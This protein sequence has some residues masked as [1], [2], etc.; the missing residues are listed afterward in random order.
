MSSGHLG[1]IEAALS[2]QKPNGGTPIVGATMLAYK[3]LYQSLGVEGDAHVVLIT[4]GSDSC[5]DFYAAQPSIPA[6]NQVEKLI[7]SGAPS[8]LGVGI[9][10]WVIGAPGSES[11]RSTLSN[12][13]IAGGTRRSPA[14]TPGSATD[15]AVG[16]CHYDMTT[17]DFESTLSEALGHI[18]S[19]VTCGAIR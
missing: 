19:V 1:A 8:A 17:G 18:L 16:D 7:G 12:L 5:A 11:G 15:P 4:D 6:G 14:C 2:A 10:T 13:A 9:K 3:H